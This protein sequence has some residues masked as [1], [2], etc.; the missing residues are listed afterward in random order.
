M[1]P[2]GIRASLAAVLLFAVSA[3]SV[4]ADPPSTTPPTTTVSETTTAPTSTDATTTETAPLV[5][6]TTDTTSTVATTTTT[7]PPTATTSRPTPLHAPKAASS[8]AGARPLVGGCS[9]AAAIVL[10]PHRAPIVLRP[11]AGRLAYPADGSVLLG[12]GRPC[13][14][15]G[16]SGS[17]AQVRSLSLFAGAVRAQRTSL[18]VGSKDVAAVT[19]LSVGGRA[20]PAAAGSQTPVGDWGVVVVGSVRGGPSAL[21]VYLLH[22]HAGLPAGTIVLVSTTPQA[23]KAGAG[24]G[25]LA[26]RKK[27]AERRRRAAAAHRPLTVTPPLGP[28]HYLFPVVGQSGYVDTYG[29]FRSDVPGGWHHGDDIFAPL[30]TPVVAVCSG[31]IN[32]VGWEKVGG[33]RLWVRDGVGDEFYYAHLSGFA[34]ADLRSTHVDAGQ[35][36]GFVGNTGDAF[37]TAP[38]L[39]FEI[40][41]R[42]LLHLGYNGAVDPTGYLDHWT[43]LDHAAAPRPAHP[44]LPTQPALRRETRYVFRELLA[45]RH[46]LR[47]PPAASERPHIHVPADANGLPVIPAPLV[48]ES[49]PLSA[50]PRSRHTHT[51][52]I[53]LAALGAIIAACLALTAAAFRRSG[54]MR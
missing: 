12:S 31:T 30:G 18:T 45:A 4:R 7:T 35:V 43:H 41:P 26:L 53:L 47:H 40:H 49:A 15:R 38:H 17:E 3:G 52:T 2:L 5:P 11:A 23:A 25:A 6:T 20:V 29:A 48:R 50:T 21:E 14:K 36:I 16:R 39:H 8:S 27:R 9:L 10:L 22:A 1:P 42:S 32:R 46:L 19:G 13:S 28:D 34:P 51:S 24:R 44:P 33:W 37:T 54:L